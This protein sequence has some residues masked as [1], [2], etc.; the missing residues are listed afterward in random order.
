M[1]IRT[2]NSKVI[3]ELQKQ[4]ETLKIQLEMEEV[5]RQAQNKK[6]G[7]DFHSEQSK[8]V[9]EYAR[10]AL[11]VEWI[12][13]PK[14]KSAVHAFTE[15]PERQVAYAVEREID[16]LKSKMGEAER[17][18]RVIH[19][20][21]ATDERGNLIVSPFRIADVV[22]TLRPSNEQEKKA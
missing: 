2:D 6:W 20:E 15:G 22:H 11:L 16:A 9:N 8:R 3:E 4:I 18:L 19:N 13:N 17:K 12:N 10:A 21:T 14:R 5:R 7:A 1:N